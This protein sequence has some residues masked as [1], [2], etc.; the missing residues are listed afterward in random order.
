M[1]A[2]WIFYGKLSSG[3]CAQSRIKRAFRAK[4]L[5]DAGCT[6]Y[7]RMVRPEDRGTCRSH[8][9]KECLSFFAEGAVKAV[10]E[11]PCQEGLE[12]HW[13]ELTILRID[14]NIPARKALLCGKPWRI[15]TGRRISP[16]PSC[17]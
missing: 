10:L 1:V 6:V 16:P 5:E 12:W 14:T 17:G 15:R 13:Y 2:G 11:A 4:R 8:G 3:I 7:F 9:R